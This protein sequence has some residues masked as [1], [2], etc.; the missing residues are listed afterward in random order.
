MAAATPR[1]MGGKP[2][3]GTSWAPVMHRL[4][5]P[6]QEAVALLYSLGQALMLGQLKRL[7]VNK[8]E[9]GTPLRWLQAHLRLMAGKW[10]GTH[11]CM[12]KKILLPQHPSPE[13]EV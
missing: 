9:V 7:K 8:T 1:N 11:L 3:T 12:C 6:V 10:V 4:L 2:G 13:Q 5:P